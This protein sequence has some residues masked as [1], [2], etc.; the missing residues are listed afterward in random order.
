MALIVNIAIGVHR[1][2][3]LNVICPGG[4]DTPG[5]RMPSQELDSLVIVDP[6]G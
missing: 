5:S 2:E 6:A 1:Q 4:E 3:S